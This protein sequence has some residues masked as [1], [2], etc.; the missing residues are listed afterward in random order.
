M[1]LTE[2]KDCEHGGYKHA[3]LFGWEGFPKPE[4]KHKPKVLHKPTGVTQVNPS[5]KK[6]Q[7]AAAM[8]IAA[9]K[10]RKAARAAAPP[11]KGEETP[12]ED[13]VPQSSDAAASSPPR[14]AKKHDLN[15]SPNHPSER[16]V[17]PPPLS[18]PPPRSNCV[19][20]TK[21]VETS[22]F[23]LRGFFMSFTVL[24]KDNLLQIKSLIMLL[25]LDHIYSRFFILDNG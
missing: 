20:R 23:S 18:T 13:E 12:S 5:T 21:I 2:Y 25:S 11:E 7:N 10:A 14:K 9:M 4:F 8:R 15:S 16:E 3:C 1:C 24:L 17:P 6:R 22:V 19:C